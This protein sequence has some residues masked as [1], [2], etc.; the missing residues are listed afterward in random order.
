MGAGN[1]KDYEKEKYIPGFPKS[2]RV[3]ILNKILDQ[4]KKSIC[5]IMCN[6]GGYGTGFFCFLPFPDKAIKLR[7]L[8]TNNHILG[9]IDIEIGKTVIF[10]VNNDKNCFTIQIDESRKVYTNINY[11]ITIIELKKEKDGI[12][13]DS[14]L[15][16]DDIILDNDI[17]DNIIEVLKNKSIYLIHYPKGKNLEQAQ[18]SIKFIDEDKYTIHHVC[19]TEKGSSGSPIFNLDNNKIIGIHKGAGKNENKWNLGTLLREPIN[20]FNE[21]FLKNDKKIENKTININNNKKNYK[22]TYIK[23]INIFDEITIIYKKTN[24]NIKDFYYDIGVKLFM[25]ETLSKEKFFGQKF[26]EKNKDKCKI[27]YKGREYELFAYFNDVIKEKED[28]NI[29]IKLKGISKITD[30]TNMFFG[31]ISL[32]SLPDIQNWDTKNITDMTSMFTYCRSLNPFPDISGWNTKKV[33]SFKNFFCYCRDIEYLPDISKWDMSSAQDVSH[34]FDCCLSLKSFPDLSKWDTRNVTNMSTLFA[35]CLLVEFLPDI[36]NWMTHNVKSM[37]LLF[38]ECHSLIFIPDISKWKTDKVEDMSKFFA[39]CYSL[40]VLPDIS[41]WNTKNVK[42][43]SKMFCGCR[44]LTSFPNILNWELNDSIKADDMF[45]DFSKKA[46]TDK[47]KEQYQS[48]FK[49]NSSI[50]SRF[51]DTMYKE[52]FKKVV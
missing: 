36:S 14:Y 15:D 2:I 47:E 22:T 48:K 5:K 21:K 8:I 23:E 30:C 40:E 43:M 4:S 17:K 7:T 32:Y 24:T 11:D 39:D 52:L 33:K 26:V 45:T 37:S 13:D 44:S 20:K 18:G 1:I 27:I 38:S 34:M 25:D 41:V 51:T 42:N 29:T 6:D 19:N 9:K 50:F 16:V 12:K 46:L 35:S 28:D 3:E 49:I 31:C 10:S